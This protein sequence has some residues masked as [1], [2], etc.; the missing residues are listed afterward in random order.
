MKVVLMSTVELL[1][2]LNDVQTWKGFA[3]HNG[4][5]NLVEWKELK[6]MY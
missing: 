2:E 4:N 1:W 5:I 3:T 6:C